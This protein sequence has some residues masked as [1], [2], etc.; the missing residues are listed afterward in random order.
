MV[1]YSF[2]RRFVSDIQAGKKTHTLRNNRKRHA[3]VGEHLQLFCA[4]RRPECFK[5]IPDPVCKFVVPVVIVVA[6]DGFGIAPSDDLGYLDPARALRPDH[7]EAFAV[8]DGFDSVRD[9]SDFW[10]KTHGTGFH[11]QWIIAWGDHPFSGLR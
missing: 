7:V 9:M 10:I 11:H 3:R 2:H 1:A 8:S 6:T 4:M 5:I